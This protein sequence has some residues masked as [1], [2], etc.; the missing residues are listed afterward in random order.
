MHSEYTNKLQAIAIAS[1][2]QSL[3]ISTCETIGKLMTNSGGIY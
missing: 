1:Y 3:T 2:I